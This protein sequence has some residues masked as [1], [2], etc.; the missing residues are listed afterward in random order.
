MLRVGPSGSFC[1]GV[2]RG[3]T[4]HTWEG[5]PGG[6]RTGPWREAQA[7]AG[8]FDRVGDM[9]LT[10]DGRYMAV[11]SAGAVEVWSVRPLRYRRS[12]YGHEGRVLAVRFSP[13]GNR[14]VSAG[15]DGTVRVWDFRAAVAE[16]PV[17]VGEPPL[18]LKVSPDGR[19]LIMG[20]YRHLASWYRREESSYALEWQVGDHYVGDGVLSADGLTL[21]T[22][23]ER[24][25]VC[26]WDLSGEE[27]RREMTPSHILWLHEGADRRPP[28]P[29]IDFRRAEIDPR[30][31]WLA[32]G[33]RDEVAIWD[34]RSGRAARTLTGHHSPVNAVAFGPDGVLASGTKGGEV[35]LWDVESGR[36]R[37]TLTAATSTVR[38][39]AF[40]RTG[41]LL[42]VTGGDASVGVWGTLD[43]K[44]RVRLAGHRGAVLSIAF[45]PDEKTVATGGADGAM[46][47]WQVAT[48]LET[49]VF[50]GQDGPVTRIAFSA[51]GRFLACGSGGAPPAYKPVIRV[52]DCGRPLIS[53]GNPSGE[54]PP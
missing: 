15:A 20:T 53:V 54:S 38:N 45:S 39:L 48:G 30:A 16:E 34:L 32:V 5:I 44:E 47:L 9:A 36:L 41:D 8:R 13:D 40:S 12:C 4:L 31:R 14:L 3:G 51:D 21:W 37:L 11:A 25:A 2:T 24:G 29:A 22:C 46:R 43:G 49:L 27:P 6:G 10:P 19:R 42:A 17:N 23:D 18:W 7:V 26:T 28:D 33:H 52:R 35:S 1:V 50:A